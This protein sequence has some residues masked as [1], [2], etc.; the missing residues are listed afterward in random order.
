M[1]LMGDLHFWSAMETSRKIVVKKMGPIFIL[2]FM[3]SILLV[4][5]TLLAGVGLI[6]AFPLFYTIVY[7]A[8]VQVSDHAEGK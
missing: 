5:S 6:L 3:L 8:L 7:G 2:T 4:I 1:I